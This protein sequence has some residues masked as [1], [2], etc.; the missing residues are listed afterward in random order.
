MP[1][2]IL[3]LSR[4]HKAVSLKG[5][6]K[7]EVG[8]T[9]RSK[10][11]TKKCKKQNEKG[12]REGVSL[13]PSVL[14]AFSSSQGK[15]RVL[16]QTDK[17]CVLNG[18]G[19]PSGTMAEEKARIRRQRR[20]RDEDKTFSSLSPHL[21]PEKGPRRARA[22]LLPPPPQPPRPIQTCSP[23]R[24]SCKGSRRRPCARRR[25]LP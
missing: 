1:G 7:G 4:L 3:S 5:P 25:R 20:R 21:T 18:D 24:R 6:Q 22:P 17:T 15:F 10:K 12:E 9:K 23:R 13:S 2:M 8:E 14:S 11:K 19:D 16:F